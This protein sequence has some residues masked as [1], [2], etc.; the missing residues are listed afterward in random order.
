MGKVYDILVRREHLGFLMGALLV[1]A[2]G[3]EGWIFALVVLFIFFVGW[4]V[5]RKYGT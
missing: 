4:P 1:S 5:I 2:A 3:T